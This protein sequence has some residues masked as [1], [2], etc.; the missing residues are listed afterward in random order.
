MEALIVIFL[1]IIVIILLNQKKNLDKRLERLD[2]ITEHTLR[3][4]RKQEQRVEQKFEAQKDLQTPILS[5]VVVPQ[6]E[7]PP[8]VE[9]KKSLRDNLLNKIDLANYVK[10]EEIPPQTTDIKPP[11]IKKKTNL[12]KFI[13]ENLLN[14]IG[15]A[16]FV[17]GIG[18]FVKYAIDNE[19]IGSFGRVAIGILAG[20]GLIG[21]AHKLRKKFLA[22]GSVLVGG[23][24]ATLYYTIY[25][26]FHDYHIFGQTQ[27]FGIMFIITAFAVLLSITYNRKE[28]AVFAIL[29]GFITPLLV[30]T[31]E[32]NYIVLFTYVMILDIGMLVLAA[33]KKWNIVN[34]ISYIFTIILY[35]AWLTNEFIDSEVPPYR[36][37]LVFASLFFVVFILMNI[38]N[39]LR[40]KVKLSPTEISILLS[41]TFF[42]FGAGLIIVNEVAPELK[43]L[44]TA[45]IAIFNF[46]LVFTLYR[47]KHID[48]NLLYLFIGLVLTF[49]SLVAP[50]QLEGNYITLFWAAESVLVL[51]LF[52]KSEIKLI[53]YASVLVML[54]TFISLMMDF[55]NV[56]FD[57]PFDSP[58]L[59]VVLNKG[60]IA[61]IVT[62]ISFILCV[63]L[64]KNVKDDNILPLVPKNIYRLA[65]ISF[66]IVSGYL[67]FLFE[68]DYQMHQTVD[69]ESP[70]YCV[71]SSYNYLFLFGLL[72]W[73]H[74]N[75]NKN[76]QRFVLALSVI[77]IL[78]YFSY[79]QPDVY[80]RAR[81][82]FLRNE[83][84]LIYFLLHYIGIIFLSGSLYLTG[85]LILN[86]IS[87]KVFRIAIWGL[88]F[89]L[90]FILSAELDHIV[91]LS[92]FEMP[93]LSDIVPEDLPAAISEFV[94]EQEY[95]LLR[96]SHLIGFP[97]LWS[98]SSFVIMLIGLKRKDTMLRIMSL[99]LFCITLVK[100]F[101]YDV[102]SMSPG[103]R[104][105]A[106]ISLGLI[107]LIVSFLYQKLRQII[108]EGELED[109]E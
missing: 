53:K 45:A 2:N 58:S 32:G 55:Y 13:G 47:N 9:E 34:I 78:T 50:I 68:I 107:L 88:V 108:F 82:Q 97:I 56:Y 11:K 93:N 42:Y 64:L 73:S 38:I 72:L 29:G 8:V 87:Q 14:K 86:S 62:V 70:V 46:V 101:A 77:G 43:G 94:W 80:L 28:L 16:I 60:F 7:I 96:S 99:T 57:Y 20:G 90:V 63:F 105:A 52:T 95:E 18:F 59:S 37:A 40:T 24:L 66:T 36:G 106:F 27:T 5:E 4:L 10:K 33:I 21:I 81:N 35:G 89:T 85:Q 100:L 74:I 75:G 26:A 65:L 71:I 44:F 48:K 22:F 3:E 17:I 12:E 51:W 39:H 109:E 104:I 76:L 103:G 83:A 98:L 84:S 67:T 69:L 91:V 30:S 15:I 23:G 6:E 41:N 54:L 1:I 19:W 31:G 61:G 102:W 92:G 49:I 25:L 79:Y